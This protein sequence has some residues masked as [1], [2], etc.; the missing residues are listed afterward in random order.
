VKLPVGAIEC[1]EFGPIEGHCDSAF[2]LISFHLFILYIYTIFNFK[3]A[4]IFKKMRI[5]IKI[6]F[7][8]ILI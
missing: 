5:K 8:Q 6:R 1:R 3:L 4:N 7:N 2:K